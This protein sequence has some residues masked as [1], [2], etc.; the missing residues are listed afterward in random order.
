MKKI[1]VNISP[2]GGVNVTPR[3]GVMMDV[4]YCE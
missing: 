1:G 2:R 4:L 3:A